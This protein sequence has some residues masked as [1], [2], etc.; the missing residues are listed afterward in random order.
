MESKLTALVDNKTWVITDLLVNKVL[1]CC[2]QVF[3]TKRLADGSIER[4]KA[5]LVAKGYN[6]QEGLDYTETLAPV[7]K[8]NTVRI[9]LAIGV[10]KG[11]DIFQLDVNNAF[12]HGHLEEEVYMQ[13]PP[14]F[15]KSDKSKGKVC[16]LL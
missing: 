4:Y 5:G 13:L 14:E 2:K 11:W 16:K 8:M 15:Y 10:S 3:K 9:L 6:Q 12:L 1:I 7:G